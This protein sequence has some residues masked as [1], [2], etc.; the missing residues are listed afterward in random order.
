MTN[1]SKSR[2]TGGGNY[3]W[4]GNVTRRPDGV[5]KVTGRACY[6]DDMVLPGM[7]YMIPFVARMPMQKYSL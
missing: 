5:D 2:G 4:V 3:R 6:G 1:D 7:L